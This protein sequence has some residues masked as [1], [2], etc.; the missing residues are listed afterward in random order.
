MVR[1]SDGTLYTGISTDVERR[2]HQHATGKGARYT[3][4]RAPVHLL[5]FSRILSHSE[6]LRHERQIKRL[7]STEKVKACTDV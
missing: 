2:V 1:C 5:A 4:K 3:S 6:A 7:H